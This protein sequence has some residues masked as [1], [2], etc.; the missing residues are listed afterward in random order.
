M[1]GDQKKAASQRAK[2]I[3]VD[4]SGFSLIPFVHRTWA[5]RGCTPTLRHAFRWP[6]LSAISG[7]T[8]QGRIFFQ[9]RR[10]TIRAPQC[11]GFLRQLLRHI[12]GRI[13]VLWD[14]ARQHKAIL[15]RDFAAK[16]RDRLSLRYVPP[17]SPEL[18]PDEGVWAHIKTHRIANLCAPDVETLE[19]HLR[20]AV[21]Y[22]RRRPSL[23][24]SFFHGS[25][26]PL[27]VKF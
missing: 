2:L 18:N 7:V 10:G 13:V 25:S 26:L 21:R 1:A 8:P 11:V 24:R 17:Y 12:P 16:H 9:L 6:K 22:I 5:P 3:F 23:V 19:T 4:E 15:T 14:N 27:I 20:R